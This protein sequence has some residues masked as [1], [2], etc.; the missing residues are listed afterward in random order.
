MR[1]GTTEDADISIINSC[2]VTAQADKKCRNLIRKIH[3]RNPDTIIAVTGCY[4][5]LKPYEIAA[6]DGVDIVLSNNNKGETYQRVLE[7]TSKGKTQVFS[8][9]TEQI[10][11]F[12]SAFSSVFVLVFVL[13]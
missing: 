4:A 1:V 2:S 7:L 11:S 12:F 3:R 10:T 8:C 6:I 9:E 13:V 5:Q